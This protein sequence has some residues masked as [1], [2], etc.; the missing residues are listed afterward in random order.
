MRQHCCLYRIWREKTSRRCDV[1]KTPTLR[2]R[3]TD[4]QTDGRTDG[5]TSPN[6]YPSV[7]R[8][9]IT[10]TLIINAKFFAK[11]LVKN[12]HNKSH[13]LL[14]KDKFLTLNAGL[15]SYYKSFFDI[16]IIPY[17]E[18]YYNRTVINQSSIFK[19]YH[20]LNYIWT[21]I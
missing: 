1:Y 19:S 8:G 11:M 20:I 17:I 3:Q 10:T 14:R 16:Q 7:S 4:G 12:R 18:L 21:T 15:A 9:I 6:L 13:Y 5:R 2:V